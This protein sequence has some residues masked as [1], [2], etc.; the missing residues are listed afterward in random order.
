MPS[1]SEMTTTAV[2]PLAWSSVRTAWRMS[3]SMSGKWTVDGRTWLRKKLRAV[4]GHVETV[5]EPDPEFAVD[6]DHRLVAEAHARLERR[7]VAAGEVGPLVAVK[8]D[9][10]AGTMGKTGHFVVRSEAGV[11]DD[12]ARGRIDGLARHAGFGGVECRHLSALLEIPDLGLA[13]RRLAEHDGAR[14]VR[15]IAIHDAAVVDLD[16]V[17]VV[18]GYQSDAAVRKCREFAEAG[19]DGRSLRAERAICGQDVVAQIALRHPFMERRETG[20]VGRV[21]HFAGAWH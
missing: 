10:V 5:L 19:G 20:L 4:L 15:L 14:D 7:P 3:L 16:D 11:G 6:G 21:R 18:D 2:Q 12:L 17:C 9:A 8:A 1:A 13:L